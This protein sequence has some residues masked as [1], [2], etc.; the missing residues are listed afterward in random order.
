MQ[1]ADVGPGTEVITT[2]M[3]CAAT[4]APIV[5]AGAVPVWA[6]VDPV[7]GNIDP[8]SVAA[9]VTERTA[10]LVAVDWCGRPCDYAGLRAAA[11]GVPIIRDA[12]HAAF[13]HADVAD[14][15]YH[16]W[17]FQAIKFLTTGDG[18]ALL[19]PDEATTDR[20]RLLRWYG[21]DRRG[22]ADFRCA[23]D[24]TEVGGKWHMND[25]AAALGLANIEGAMENARLQALNAGHLALTLVDT[26]GFAKPPWRRNCSWWLYTVLS[27]DR[28]AF[29]AFLAEWGID[30]SEVHRRNDLHPGFAFASG[31]WN[32]YGT[33]AANIMGRRPGLDAFSARQLA[34]PV[35]WW[36][37]ESEMEYIAQAVQ[38]WAHDKEVTPW[39]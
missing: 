28:D 31:E 1:C 22:N 5:L 20:A 7:T 12:A 36:L 34:I 16:A 18:G 24:I 17:S 39:V 26:P 11:P 21:L 6:D 10:A 32:G 14:A 35:G 33:V 2:P 37:A 9:L 38:A 25:L 19:C 29:G 15:D 23:Q 8:A 4:N 30:T 13:Q 27:D 3:T